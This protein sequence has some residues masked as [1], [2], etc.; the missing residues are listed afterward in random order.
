MRRDT[1]MKR[2]NVRAALAAVGVLRGRFVYCDVDATD[3][4]LLSSVAGQLL[5]NA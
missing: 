3:M 1:L 5:A 4:V 2:I